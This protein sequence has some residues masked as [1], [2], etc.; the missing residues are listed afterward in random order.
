M[1]VQLKL[2]QKP[3]LSQFERDR[4]KNRAC[5]V[6]TLIA[7]VAKC[8]QAHPQVPVREQHASVGAAIQNM[9]LCAHG[10]GFGAKMVSGRKADDL[11]LAA[12]LGLTANEQLF[13]FVCIGTIGSDQRN[14]ARPNVAD[15]LTIW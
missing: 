6:P 15:H 14:T 13:G 9:L 10:L 8:T 3:D 1:F 2:N 12:A 7:V 4:E 5:A 11:E